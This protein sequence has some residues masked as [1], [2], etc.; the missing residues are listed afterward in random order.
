MPN[1]W[2]DGP[3]ALPSGL[4]PCQVRS[5]E[6]AAGG[7]Q[8]L[9]AARQIYDKLAQEQEVRK[10]LEQ[11]KDEHQR[12]MASLKHE[13]SMLQH[14]SK[15]QQTQLHSASSSPVKASYQL[16]EIATS[17]VSSSLQR[18]SN[19]DAAQ[20]KE[21]EDLIAEI[22]KLQGELRHREPDSAEG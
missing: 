1:V 22:S 21:R 13:L 12:M 2:E 17:H 11:E 14:N 4:A 8:V 15:Q 16:V 18:L 9:A 6:G 20:D 7:C 19:L 3:R 5:S 10:V